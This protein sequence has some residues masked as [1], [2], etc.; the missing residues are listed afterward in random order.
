MK[1]ILITGNNEGIGLGLYNYLKYDYNV[2]GYDLAHGQNVALEPTYSEV[3]EKCGDMDVIILN[4]HTGEQHSMLAELYALYKEKRIHCVV[5]GSMVTQYYDDKEL[6]PKQ[7]NFLKYYEDKKN[8]D[9]KF[10]VIQSKG[11]KPFRITM[12]RPSWVETPLAK[13]YDGKKLSVTSVVQAIVDIIHSHYHITTLNL[14]E[15]E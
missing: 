7:F 9:D 11:Q 8:L 3:I 2:I 12:V 5:L 15:I 6:V 1:N 14:E 4:A 10:K 13:E